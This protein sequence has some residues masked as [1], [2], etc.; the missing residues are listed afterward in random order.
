MDLLDLIHD[1]EFIDSDTVRKINRFCRTDAFRASCV[2]TS[3]WAWRALLLE[4]EH[5]FVHP[6]VGPLT[7]DVLDFVNFVIWLALII[8]THI[9]CGY[10]A[11][12]FIMNGLM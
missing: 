6:V 5:T 3:I 12:N 8:G 4:L 10:L 11:T 1:L 2:L 9:C 7:I